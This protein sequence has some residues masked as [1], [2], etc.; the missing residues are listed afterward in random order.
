MTDQ[1]TPN[2]PS[3][4]FDA[5][6]RFYLALGFERSWRDQGWMILERGDLTLEF[7]PY[8]DLDPATSS[9][10]CCLRLDDLDGFYA[11]CRGNGIAEK[12]T[13]WPR[14]HPPRDMGPIVMAALID[15]D[16]TL[17]RLIQN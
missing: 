9:F 13:G 11:V 4:D 16:G 8:P 1:A 10:G 5:T 7:F 15:P 6:E 3:R 12:T 14:L 17:V 2:L